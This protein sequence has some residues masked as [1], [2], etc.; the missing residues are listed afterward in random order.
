MALLE[1]NVNN[2]CDLLKQP[3]NQLLHTVTGGNL[4]AVLRVLSRGYALNFEAKIPDGNTKHKST[5]LRFF[6]LLLYLHTRNQT[7][8]SQMAT[9]KCQKSMKLV[10]QTQ[11]RPLF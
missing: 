10:H 2:A 1:I 9:S 5:F 3:T 4:S 11:F 8:N 7:Q 6:V